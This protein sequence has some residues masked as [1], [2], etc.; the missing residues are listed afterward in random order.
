MCS[1]LNC[2]NTY[3]KLSA[4]SSL[5]RFPKD[6]GRCARWVQ[7]TRR[8]D[9][10]GKSPLYLYNNCRLCSK[11]FE[12]G[13]I[14]CTGRLVWNAVPT[15]FDVPNPPKPITPKR[16]LPARC[17]GDEPK[18][19]Q[20]RGKPTPSS[21]LA[22]PPPPPTP[23]PPTAPPPTPPPPCKKTPNKKSEKEPTTSRRDEPSTSHSV[24]RHARV[25]ICRLRAKVKKL[26]TALK[27]ANKN[28]NSIEQAIDI[29]KNYLNEMS[30]KFFAS[31][32][33][34]SKFRTKGHK[35]TQDDKALAFALYN[36]GPQ[37]YEFL[38]KLK[39]FTLPSVSSLK[40]L[41]KLEK[42]P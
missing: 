21:T 8:K 28:A 34:L 37:A 29:A 24:P 18:A 26:E 30:L 20:C 42:K 22:P 9:L 5:Y 31:Q 41:K 27:G 17:K 19:K 40:P 16:K 14:L 25:K 23:P 1:A 12:D 6:P 2:T 10:L 39:I 11:H 33:Q 7:N 4:G 35:Y 3:T 15:K 13:Q 38:R 36:N 32:L